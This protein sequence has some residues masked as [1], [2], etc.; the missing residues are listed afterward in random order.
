MAYFS[1]DRKRQAQM[2]TARFEIEQVFVEVI[3]ELIFVQEKLVQR[4]KD[5]NDAE[6]IEKLKTEKDLNEAYIKLIAEQ[7]DLT[8]RHEETVLTKTLEITK[9]D[10]AARAELAI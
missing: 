6:L 7:K 9:G 5:T 3:R 4:I 8:G 2:D 1:E 10:H